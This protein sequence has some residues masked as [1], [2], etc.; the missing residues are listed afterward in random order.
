[1]KTTKIQNCENQRQT[2][3]QCEGTVTKMQ[4]L[5]AGAVSCN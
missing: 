4:T 1:M 3:S 2:Q 5:G